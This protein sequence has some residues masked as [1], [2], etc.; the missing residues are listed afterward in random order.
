MRRSTLSLTALGDQ[1]YTAACGSNEKYI[2]HLIKQLRR[3]VD[4]ELSQ[5][6]RAVVIGYYFESK[7]VSE[8]AKERGVNKSTVSRTLSR[9]RARL[10]LALR[11]AEPLVDD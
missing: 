3:A 1:A 10:S 11:Y 2:A 7:S 5:H 6:Q 8:I 9:A 4:S